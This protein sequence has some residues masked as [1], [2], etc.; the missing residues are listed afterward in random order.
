MHV[1]AWYTLVSGSVIVAALVSSAAFVPHC[2]TC[3]HYTGGNRA[4]FS[5][6]EEGASQMFY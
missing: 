6:T 1:G 4:V 3:A 2:Y 5:A